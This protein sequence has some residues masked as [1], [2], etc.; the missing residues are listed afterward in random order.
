MGMYDDTANIAMIKKATGEDKIFYVGY[1][2]G[3]GQMHY[4]LSH[5]EDTLVQSLHRVVHLAPCFVAHVPNWTKSI[6]DSTLFKF[7]DK[8]IYAINGPNWAAD[9]KTIRKEFGF[10]V[11]EA[12][13]RVGGQGQ[14]A[15]SLQYWTTN[16]VTDRFQEP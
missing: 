10:A 14:G 16:G 11:W 7:Q 9:L 3:T 12:L 4:A 15:Q 5:I 1:S 8:G 13:K 2:Q 6:S